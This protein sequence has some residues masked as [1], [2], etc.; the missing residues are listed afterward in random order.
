MWSLKKLFK[1]SSGQ[2]F[3]PKE[4][5]SGVPSVEQK[6]ADSVSLERQL[7]LEGSRGR[8]MRKSQLSPRGSAKRKKAKKK[9]HLP[10][11][12]TERVLLRGALQD[13]NKEMHRLGG[14]K[15]SLEYSMDK[16][17]RELTSTQ[18]TELRLRAKASQLLKIEATLGKEKAATK[19]KLVALDKRIEKVKAI[20]RELKDV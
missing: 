9:V 8:T 7:F 17:S 13:L 3:P 16:V 5:K 11:I 10:K 20:R 15:R 18:N 6:L 14:Q 4:D 2:N 12:S 1:K 19:D